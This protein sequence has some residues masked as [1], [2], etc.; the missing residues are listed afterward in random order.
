M[1]AKV[2]MVVPHPLISHDEEDYRKIGAE[3][4]TRP[5]QTEEEII[6]AAGEADFVLTFKKPFNQKVMA[7]L[8]RCRMVNGEWPQWL[9]NTEVKDKFQQRWGKPLA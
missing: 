7:Q 1:T 5:C 8:E 4:N 6:G 2:V 9:I 3:F